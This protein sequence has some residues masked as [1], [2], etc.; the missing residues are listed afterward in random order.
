MKKF[1]PFWLVLIFCVGLNPAWAQD[2]TVTGKVTSLD[3]G[4]AL[5][6]VNVVLKGTAIGTVTDIDGNYRLSIPQAGGIL[7]FSFVGLVSQELDVG[8]RSVV[9][10]QMTPDITQLSEVVVTAVGIEREKRALGYAVTNM[11]AGNIQQKAEGDVI[12]A[13]T[14]KVPGVNIQGSNGA[15]GASTNIVI[16]G[17]SSILG[18]NQPLFVVDGIP[19]DNTSLRTQNT[20]ISGAPYSSRA[21]D[22][23]P[24]DIAS[25]SVL[26]GAAASALYGSRAAN[27]VILITTKSGQGGA[28]KGLEVT[29]QSSYS[30]EEVAGIPEYQNRFGQGGTTGG[31]SGVY[32]PAFFGSWGPGD[33]DIGN[34]VDWQGNTVDFAIVPDNVEDFFET[35]SN[36]ENSISITHGSENSNVALTATH[37]DTDGFIPN[38]ELSRTNIKLGGNAKLSNGLYVGGSLSY[39]Y[40]TQQGPPTGGGG[41]VSSGFS[42]QL[43][44]MPRSYDPYLYPFI[45]ENNQDSH[46]RS[47][48]D[49]PLFSAFENPFTSRVSRVFAN[50]SL[51]YDINDWLN[52]TYK[53]GFDNY[54]QNNKQV[55]AASSQFAPAGNITVDD[56]WFRSVES[57]F[58]IT[59]SKDITEDIN[60][61]AL[62]GHNFNQREQ[63]RQ[64]FSGTG[65]TVFGIDD[66]DNTQNVVPN[67]GTYFKRR[68]VG[69][70]TDVSLSY[71]DYLFLGF[72]ARNDWS[73]TLPQGDNSF[74]YPAGTLGFV[75][76][77]ALDL[78]SNVLSFGKLRFAYGKVGNDAPVYSTQERLYINPNF[79]TLLGNVTFPFNN[80]A[81]LTLSNTLGNPNLTPEFTT[82][83]E[84]GTELNFFQGRLNLDV[85]YF[86]RETTD[87][88]FSVPRPPSF[89][90]TSETLNAGK[91]SN[92]GIEIGLDVT[93]VEL[94]NGFKWNV[95]ASYTQIENKV[96]ELIEGVERIGVGTSNFFTLGTYAVPGE[97][98][99]VI[100][101][102]SVARDDDGNRLINPSNGY[103]I[104]N[105]DNTTIIG[106]PNP[107][108][109]LGVTNTLSYKGFSL[110]FL[111]DWKQGGDLYSAT[112]ASMRGRGVLEETAVG[113]VRQ[114]AFLLPG[115]LGD[116]SNPGTPLLD[117]EN[118]PIPN[119]IQIDA[120]D[121]FWRTSSNAPAE[122]SVYDATVIRLREVG[123]T[124]EFPESLLSNVFLGSAS[125]TLIGRNLWFNAP[126][127]PD[128][129]DPE[130]N[131]RGS[132]NGQGME[133]AYVPNARRYG[134][135]VRLT[136]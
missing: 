23:D 67:G 77:D 117:G 74:F 129:Y 62:V 101:G 46:Y 70:Y 14:G 22:I 15:P 33:N 107:D 36:L 18:S 135:S 10:L 76:T 34:V 2:R 125:I 89:G 45:D 28:R 32:S 80:T 88:I 75:F 19:F 54:T 26:K 114:Q 97:P 106:D 55:F 65:I 3:D 86:N 64:S 133:F 24:N 20:L 13:L 9:D 47:G 35:G 39:I 5:P 59:A 7:V 128:G 132:G 131:G 25:L 21:L 37:L 12:R 57:N 16:R 41:V 122:L 17:N 103:W 109:I 96:E 60:I 111:I 99:G 130:T 31:G 48:E 69:L 110:N 78:Q 4:Q 127:I 118:N 91:V 50:T 100:Q 126:N 108:F 116:V 102:S 61:R 29:F 121:Y 73:S 120:N 52:V 58:I 81:G 6:G 119:N 95:F 93:P 115:I 27:G 44:F 38:S 112:L 87:Q 49:H 68:L 134:V 63:D 123:L 90:F 71:R 72:T 8:A 82:E 92:E 85:T 104:T 66:L 79:G 30:I 11:E 40:T 43:W 94:S 105:P 113:D 136:F 83:F 98:F 56:S 84:V 124:Y 51:G 1:L 42:T 53:I